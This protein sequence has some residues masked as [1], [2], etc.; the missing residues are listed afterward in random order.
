MAFAFINKNSRR[1]TANP[2]SH[3][4]LPLATDNL[5]SVG[6]NE[7]PSGKEDGSAEQAMDIQ[8]N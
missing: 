1:I 8:E 7:L 4:A 6:I 3:P 5:D 2:I